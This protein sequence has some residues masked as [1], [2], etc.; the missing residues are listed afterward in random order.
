MKQVVLAP[1]TA[2]ASIE[3]RTKMAMMAAQNCIAGVNAQRPP[4]IVNPEVLAR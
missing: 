4:N 3:T 2:S 1:H